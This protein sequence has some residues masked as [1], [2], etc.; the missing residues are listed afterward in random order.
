DVAHLGVLGGLHLDEGGAGELGQA[1]CDLGLSHPGGADHDD[2]LGRD[3]VAQRPLHLLASPAIAQRDRHRPL[4][5]FLADDVS[6]ELRDDLAG[7]QRLH[8]PSS[9]KTSWSLV[10]TQI[11]AAMRIAFSA[12]SRAVRFVLSRSARAAA[13]A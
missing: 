11:S 10:Y 1:P 6:V 13:R 3:L 7:R 8:G 12:I 9:S 5:L 4:R 2:V